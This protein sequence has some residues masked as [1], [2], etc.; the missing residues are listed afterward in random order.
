MVFK[1]LYDYEFYK[2]IDNWI[3]FR[4]M[5]M[6][7]NKRFT[8]VNMGLDGQ[9][10]KDT[11]KIMTVEDVVDLLNSLS[12]ENEQL[13]SERDYYKELCESEGLLYD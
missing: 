2:W 12:D 11:G 10:I 9:L 3:Y 7:E 4:V 6:T 8:I 5:W 1:I 13:K